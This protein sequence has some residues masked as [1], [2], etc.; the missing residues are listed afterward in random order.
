M[1]LVGFQLDVTLL[2][3][4]VA[5]TLLG[6]RLAVTLLGFQSASVHGGDLVAYLAL[7]GWKAGCVAEAHAI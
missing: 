4:R 3:F 5:V 7:A 1:W 6:F 2:G